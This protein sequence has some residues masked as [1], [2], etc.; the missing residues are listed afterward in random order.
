L[1]KLTPKTAKPLVLILLIIATT[2][3][4]LTFTPQVKATT[5]IISMDPTYGYVGTLVNLQANITSTNGQYEIKLDETLITSGTATENDVNATFNIPDATQGDHNVTV[6]DVD[7]GE[8]A[9]AIFNIDTAYLLKTNA[10]ALPTQLQE[11]DPVTINATITGGTQTTLYTANLTVTNPNNTKYTVPV[12]ITTSE[13]GTGIVYLTYPDQ[14]TSASTNL[15]GT[16]TATYNETSASTTF[17]IGLTKSAEYHRTQTI[18]VKAVYQPFENVTVA[19]S[20]NFIYN[21]ENWTADDTGIIHYTNWTVPEDAL[22][23]TYTVRITSN[24]TKKTPE[25]AQNFTVPGYAIDFTTRNLA[26]EPVIEVT[27]KAIENGVLATSNTSDYNGYLRLRLESGTY[28]CEAYFRGIRVGENSITITGDTSLNFS[29]S[30]TNLRVIVTDNNSNPIPEVT[31]NLIEENKTLTTNLNGTVAFTSLLPNNTYTLNSSRYNM[32]FDTTTIP[33]LPA[34]AWYNASI[35]L[36]MLTLQVTVFD[37]SGNLINNAL[38]RIRERIAGVY[39]EG[40]TINGILTHDFLL[41]R[42]DIEIYS[43]GIRLN[44]TT[45]DLNQTIVAVQIKCQLFGLNVSIRIIDYFGQPIPNANVTLQNGGYGTSSLT[46]G[47]GTATFTNVIGG[48]LQL[49]VYMLG[50]SEPCVAETA[51]ITN[52]TTIA[53]KID[54]YSLLAGLLVETNQLITVII[55]ILIVIFMLSIE[56]LRRRR[57]KTQKTETQNKNKESGG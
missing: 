4:T 43:N 50:Q 26:E 24:L 11:G 52:S 37:A 18:D 17:F 10:P 39:F 30:L 13:A 19:I 44:G 5:T 8:N 28:V 7:N 15:T 25:D 45:V 35:I 2:L 14:F 31:V 9:T 33:E 41:G 51:G 53:I 34:A 6:F 20:G 3:T 48:D 55:I 46:T 42:Y 38:V 32:P 27:L 49:A 21:I 36:P 56:I 1:T 16:Y 29:C 23:D 57:H 40:T 47:D 12:N 22:I 54:R